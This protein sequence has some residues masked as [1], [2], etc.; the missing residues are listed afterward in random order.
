MQFKYIVN[1]V[2]IQKRSKEKLTFPITQ[3]ISYKV[4]L[5]HYYTKDADSTLQILHY[6]KSN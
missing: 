1:I 4:D 5:V 2:S 6:L 3:H